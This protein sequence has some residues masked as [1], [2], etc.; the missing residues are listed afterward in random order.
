MTE[1][2]KTAL[3]LSSEEKRLPISPFT[4]IA[5]FESAQRVAQA[6]MSADIA[7][8]QFKGNIGNTLIAM[9]MAQRTGSSILAIMQSLN[10][11]HGKPSFSSAYCIA[12]LNQSGRF[13]EPVHFAFQGEEGTDAWG[14]RAVGITKRG[15]EIK[16]LGA[17][18]TSVV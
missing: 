10:V 1:E 3:V 7:P 5:G 12:A 13:V 15:T 2:T 8:Q 16:G 14:C 6:L 17:T 9:E 11:I 4:S 18:V